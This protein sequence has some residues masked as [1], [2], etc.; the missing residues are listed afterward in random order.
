M[1]L[2]MLLKFSYVADMDS[3]VFNAEF[4]P[5]IACVSISSNFKLIYWI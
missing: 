1:H 4:M 2:L 3:P 5:V